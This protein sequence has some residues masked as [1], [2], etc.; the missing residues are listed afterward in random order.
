[1]TNICSYTYFFVVFTMLNP[2][3]FAA[4]CG[5]ANG[6]IFKSFISKFFFDFEEVDIFSDIFSFALALHLKVFD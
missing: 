4:S 6:L 3:G 1:M 5:I 2:Q